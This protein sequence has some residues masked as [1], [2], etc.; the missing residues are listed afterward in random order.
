MA[1]AIR[2]DHLLRSGAVPDATALAR[3]AR[4]TQPRMTQILNLTLLAPDI[5][6]RLLFLGPVEEGKPEVSEKGLRKACAVVAWERQRI[7]LGVQNELNV[8]EMRKRHS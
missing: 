7:A 1:L 6:E 5:Q 8:N 2:C 3:L 4:V